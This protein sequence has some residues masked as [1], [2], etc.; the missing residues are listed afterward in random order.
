[1]VVL[2]KDADLPLLN[3]DWLIDY[4]IKQRRPRQPSPEWQRR[5]EEA[6]TAGP[7][8]DPTVER[9][10]QRV[11]AAQLKA[12]AAGEAPRTALDALLATVSTER[13]EAVEH[14][15]WQLQIQSLHGGVSLT[16]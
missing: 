4:K 3:E 2:L 5:I 10:A 6:M 12:C 14:R 7:R 8:S 1:M 15:V 13:R 16:A 9:E 11:F